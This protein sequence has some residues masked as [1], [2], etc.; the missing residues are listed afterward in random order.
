[1]ETNPTLWQAS[2]SSLA[3]DARSW[4]LLLVDHF[5]KSMMGM[6]TSAAVVDGS[7]LPIE[8]IVVE[9]ISGV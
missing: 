7:S 1:M 9:R 6:L 2:T 8:S 5:E 4:A 3:T